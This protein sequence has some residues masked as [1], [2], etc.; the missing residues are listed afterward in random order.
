[1]KVLDIITLSD[2]IDYHYGYSDYQGRWWET[3]PPP[4]K[5]EGHVFLQT[6]P[7]PLGSDVWDWLTLS[8]LT[9]DEEEED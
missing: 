2:I 9:Y 6:H 8:F 4:S 3:Y 7:T 1:M 5:I